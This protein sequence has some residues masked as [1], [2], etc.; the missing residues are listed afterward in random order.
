VERSLERR[1]LGC[2]KPL[3]GAL[4]GFDHHQGHPYAGPMHGLTVAQPVLEE[5]DGL[6]RQD[7]LL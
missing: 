3:A 1:V 5:V 2:L 7:V 6:E 4:V